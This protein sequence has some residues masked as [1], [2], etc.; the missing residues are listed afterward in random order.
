MK[1]LCL[2]VAGLCILP[3]A[4]QGAPPKAPEPPGVELF[5]DAPWLQPTSTLEFRFPRPM[6]SRDEIGLVPKQSPAVIQ[7]AVAGKFTWLSR[8]SGVFVPEAAWPL[9][10]EFA[11]TLAKGAKAVDGQPLPGSFRATLRTPPFARTAIRGDGDSDA[12]RPLPKIFVAFNLAVEIAKAE[13]LFQFVDST[14][15]K[16]AAKVRYGTRGDY[17]PLKPEHEDWD[18]RWRLAKKGAV[19]EPEEEE[20]E[21][22]DDDAAEKAPPLPNRLVIKPAMPLTPGGVWRMEMK[23]GLKSKVGGKQISEPLVVP[24]GAVRPFTISELQP[25]NFINSGRSVMLEFSHGLAPDITPETAAKFFRV[26]PAVPNLRFD[27]WSTSLTMHGD[28]ELGREYRLEVDAAVISEDGLPFQGDRRSTFKFAPVAPRLYLPAITGHQIRSGQRKFE[29]LSANLKSL[30]VTAQVVAPTDAAASIKAFEKY[31][32]EGGDSDEQYQRLP[33]GS[34]RGKTIFERTIELPVGAVD[35]RQQTALDWN[36]I[37]GAQKAGVIFLTLEGEPVAGVA[38]KRPGAQA[39]IQLTDIGVLWKKIAEGLQVTAFSMETGHPIEGVSVALLNSQFARTGR[40][41]TDATGTATVALAPELAWLVVTKGDDVH[42]QTIGTGGGELP[43][44]AFRVP[45]NY[46]DWAPQP[47]KPLELRSIIFTDRPLYRP[48]ETVHVKGIVR[49][50]A[51][52]GLKPRGGLEGALKLRDPRGREVSETD[53][54][55]DERGAFDANLELGTAGNGRY[56]LMLDLQKAPGTQWQQGFN[57]KFEVADFQPNAFELNLPLAGRLAP[58]AEVSAK[59]TAKYFFGAPLTKADGRWTLR[60]V[61]DIFAPAGFEAWHFGEEDNSEGKILTLR[62]EGAFAGAD[63]FEIKPQLPTVK[64]APYKGVLTVEVTDINQQTVSESR[65]FHRDAADFYLGLAVPEGA[66]FRPGDEIAGRAV[67]IQP[68]GKPVA[69]PVEV[70]AELIHVRFETVRVQ[71]AG[72]AISFRSEKV[73]EVVGKATGRTLQPLLLSEAWEVRDG[74]SVTFKAAKAGQYRLRMTAKDAA[75]REVTSE[76]PVFVTGADEVAWDYRNPAQIDLVA[77]KVEYRPGDTARLLVKTPISGEALVTVE[78]DERILRTMRVKLEG[79]APAIE[80]PLEKSDAPNVFV[81]M[82][83]IR[84]REQ[85]T[86]KFKTPEYRYG[87][88]MLRVSDPAQRL[89]VEI[90]PARITVEPGDE[91]DTEV[92]VRDGAGAAVTDAEVTFF[93]PDDGILALTGYERPA[94][95]P[96]FDAPFSLAIRTGLTLFELL[97][98]DPAALEFSNKGYLIGG[99]GL[100]G[101]GLKLRRDFPGTACWFPSLKTDAAG[102]VRVRFPAPDALTRYRLVA[103]AHAGAKLFGSGES[104]FSIRKPLMLLSALG[105]FANVGDEIIAR[106]VVR[107]DTGADA[108]AEVAL[109]LDS[110]AEP[111]KPGADATKTRVEMK[112]GEARAV[113]FPVRLRAMGKAEWKWNARVEAGGKTFEDHVLAALTVGSSSPVLRETYVTELSPASTDLLAGVNPQ[114]LEGTGVVAVTVANT[115]LASLR[116][117]ANRLLEY[118]YGCAE[119]TISSLI[120]WALLPELRP[121]MPDLAKTDEEARAVIAK[122]LDRLFTMQTGNGGLSYWPGG[123]YPSVF[124]S[125][126]GAF[127]CA[128]LAKQDIDLPPGHE[129]LLKYLSGELRG[130]AKIREE[131][132]L[133]DRVL[134]LYA[135]AAFGRAEPA[136]HEEL[137]RRR[138]ELSY[139]SR[140]LLALAILEAGGPAAMVDDL[141]SFKTA[142]PETFSW[143]GGAARERAVQL[144]AWSRY[145]P[146]AAEVGRLTKELLGFRMNGHWGTTQ[147]NAWALLALARYYTAAEDGG[148]P[149]KGTLVRGANELPFHVTKEK[150]SVTEATAFAP[151]QPLGAISVRNPAKGTLFGETR[152]VVRPPAAAQPQQ[153]RGYAVSRTYRKLADDGS[154]QEAAELKVGD[155]VLVTLRVE[156]TRPGHFVAIDDPLPAILEAVNPAFQSQQV[157]GANAEAREWVSDYREMRADRVLYFCDHLPEGAFTFRYLARVRSAGTATAGPTKVEEMYRPER[158]GL[159]ESAVLTSRVAEVK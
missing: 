66:V 144:L 72:K 61:R 94:P 151:V 70:S 132:A 69:Q 124:P 101:P 73:E 92:R 91:V 150:P 68:D 2:L 39:L 24:L 153:D 123:P 149:V 77:D 56:S 128:I 10:G 30:K 49:D 93:A 5:A 35:A 15:R 142:A 134:A 17:F 113:D 50:T 40:G 98:E 88:A 6:V 109:Q 32:L 85:S 25:S 23:R 158:F 120:P 64:D 103:V 141:L 130:V 20:E 79:N 52:S 145:K 106:A 95:G 105:Q 19:A 43:M 87:L 42:A 1:F 140:A 14:G 18:E 21:M 143:F 112:N 107:N 96:I 147:Q 111:A 102:K 114:L 118:P 60:Y 54:R 83:L 58:G 9:G 127:V 46:S 86:R 156:T 13:E 108:V 139:E 99:G 152:F 65:L 135:L 137:F 62:G 84:G 7:P 115:R 76:L 8:S 31:N 157:G 75:G 133:A 59:V 104:A 148:K 117:G 55:T 16:V 51:G 57:C 80:I 3:F 89:Q 38:G 116:E 41:T 47:D 138:K 136:Y 36:E 34:I 97:P 4:S 129:A 78:R 12:A 119:Q 11:V 125:A 37:L 63:G 154:V 90:T 27:G 126:Y 110:T 44:S 146:K 155:R 45:I 81:S 22:P 74:A 82:V 29:A 159:G 131:Q 33:A 71:G 121:V 67:A 48:G 26:E 53:I 28:F 122:G 100:E